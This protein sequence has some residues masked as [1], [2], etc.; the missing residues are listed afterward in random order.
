MEQSDPI[1]RFRHDIHRLR[2]VYNVSFPSALKIWRYAAHHILWESLDTKIMC[3][4]TCAVA[5]RGHGPL[6][7]ER[8]ERTLEK[9]LDTIKHRGPD[10]NG[11]WVSEE[12]RVG[13]NGFITPSRGYT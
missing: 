9:S 8:R 5:L 6:A 1:E 2:H 13:M 10:A 7:K 12:C 11:H 4:I 3:G